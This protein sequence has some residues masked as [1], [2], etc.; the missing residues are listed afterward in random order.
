VSFVADPGTG[1]WIADPYNESGVNPWQVVGGTSLSAPAWAGLL[2]LV[3]QGRAAAGTPTLNSSSPTESQRDLYSLSANDYHAVTSGSNGGF[4]A[5]PGYNLVAGLGSPVGN[6]L[7]P[8]L[9]AGNYPTTGRV[10]PISANLNANPGYVNGGSGGTTNVINVFAALT[11]SSPGQD[12]A[13]FGAASAPVAPAPLA[14]SVPA[15]VNSTTLSTSALSTSVSPVAFDIG[16]ARS[17]V[18]STAFVSSS[19]PVPSAAASIDGRFLGFA[20]SE[21]ALSAFWSTAAPN[22]L[23]MSPPAAFG[24]A[25]AN[26]PAPTAAMTG[27]SGRGTKDPRDTSAA[28]SPDALSSPLLEPAVLTPD[29]SDCFWIWQE[30]VDSSA[31]VSSEGH[32]AATN[33]MA[34][35]HGIELAGPSGAEGGE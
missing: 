35:G 9:V 30:A 23:A 3:N 31:D 14:I 29:L 32:G 33:G 21:Q 7:V 19:T 4:N 18:A 27:V 25:W 1:A 24:P 34:R 8:D 20:A 2:A 13:S 26:N 12:N 10:A 16:Q 6:L 28:F 11:L 17:A 22:G 5:A 15:P